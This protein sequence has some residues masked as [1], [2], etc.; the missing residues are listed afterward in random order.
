MHDNKLNTENKIKEKMNKNELKNKEINECLLE[1]LV[2]YYEFRKT[3]KQNR[4]LKTK[5]RRY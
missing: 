2:E 5:L 4:T 3:Y 1:C